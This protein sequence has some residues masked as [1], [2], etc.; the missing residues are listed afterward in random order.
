MLQEE[1]FLGVTYDN[2]TYFD[3]KSEGGKLKAY[4]AEKTN[5]SR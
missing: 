5:S 2:R 1:F 4:G 3:H